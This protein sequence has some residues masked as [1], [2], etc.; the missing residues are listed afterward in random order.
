MY[1]NRHIRA[2]NGADPTTDAARGIHN[3]GEEIAPNRNLPG[4]RDNL[5]WAHLDTQFA[6][7]AVILV[8][9]YAGH[10]LTSNPASAHRSLICLSP[11]ASE[12]ADSEV[13]QEYP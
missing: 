8:Y 7:L 12:A 3:L 13:V 4:H 10:R 11:T 1:L 5:L 2:G 9:G 6:S